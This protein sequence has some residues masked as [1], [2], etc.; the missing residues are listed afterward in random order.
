MMIRL[1]LD[2]YCGCIV[3]ETLPEPLVA[4]RLSRQPEL[5][6]CPISK[7]PAYVSTANAE[8]VSIFDQEG[9]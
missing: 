1:T 9:A 6:Y 8:T 5:F 7:E 3:T 4:V 2:L